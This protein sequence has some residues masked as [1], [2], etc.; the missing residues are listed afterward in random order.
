MKPSLRLEGTRDL[1]KAL[2]D[3]EGLAAKKVAIDAMTDSLDPVVRDAKAIVRRRTG[4][5]AGSIGIGKRLTKR[6]KSMNR[7]IAPVEVYVGP[8]V[9]N[10]GGRRA[11][12]HAH[13]VEF[14]TQH[15]RPFPYMRPAWQANVRKVFDNLAGNMRARL[16]K[17][18]AKA[19]TK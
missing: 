4:A 14:G 16:A 8:G 3:L 17:I 10:R 7:P 1:E 15:S 18:V 12:A 2:S 13:L 9:A 6:Q 19:R 11:V 5:L